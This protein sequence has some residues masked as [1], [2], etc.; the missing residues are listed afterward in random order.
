MSRGVGFVAT[1]V[2][3]AVMGGSR[4]GRAQDHAH[5]AEVWKWTPEQ[6]QQ[7]VN[8]VR[9]GK[10]LKPKQWPNGAKVAV[11]ISFDFDTEPVW[12]GFQK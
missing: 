3:V 10:S 2:M 4:V 6:I 5:D 11:S 7:Q 1:I 8:K 9:A 12:L